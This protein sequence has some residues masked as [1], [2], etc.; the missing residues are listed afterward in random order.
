MKFQAATDT[1]PAAWIITATVTDEDGN[2]RIFKG[3]VSENSTSANSVW[4]KEESTS[5][6]A[7]DQPGQYIELK[8]PGYAAINDACKDLAADKLT[9]TDVGT[10]T[11]ATNSNDLGLKSK[12]FTLTNGSEGGDV[13]LSGVGVTILSN[14]IIEATHP[15][16]GKIQIGRIDLVTFDN[17]YGLEGV[18]NSY[19]KTTA[20]SG[21]PKLC[22]AGE[23]GTGALK[24]SSLE[25]SNVD[26]STEFADM[27]VTQRGFQA[28]SRIITVSDSI[29]EELVNLKR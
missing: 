12:N 27:I 4:L 29:L 8:H 15:D 17:P 3:Q 26:I 6:P 14:G 24:T 2:D 28:N 18:G 1:E 9:K 13:A 22:Q 11:A 23:N 16:L 19:F 5:V 25:M 21:D 7:D 20:N 10:I